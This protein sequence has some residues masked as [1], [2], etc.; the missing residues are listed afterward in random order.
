MLFQKPTTDLYLASRNVGLNGLSESRISRYEVRH[1]SIRRMCVT[2][3][4]SVNAPSWTA[5]NHSQYPLLVPNVLSYAML[6]CPKKVQ[7][8]STPSNLLFLF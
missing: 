4:T 7:F 2:T 3:D 6:P 8:S 1:A 5:M